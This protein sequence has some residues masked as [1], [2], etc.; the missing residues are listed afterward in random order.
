M[1]QLSMIQPAP[2]GTAVDS[3]TRAALESSGEFT[4]REDG[5]YRFV[6]SNQEEWSLI[7]LPNKVRPTVQKLVLPNGVV[8]WYS[9]IHT[10]E[11]LFEYKQN[12]SA[13]P[14]RKHMVAVTL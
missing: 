5:S 2:A 12:M 1:E 13:V 10:G 11:A 14:S 7:G 8:F 4:K 9:A 6:Q 3:E